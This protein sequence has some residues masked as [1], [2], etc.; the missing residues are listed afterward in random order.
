MIGCHDQRDDR[1]TR[2][3]GDI[4]ER[5]AVTTECLRKLSLLLEVIKSREL[6][7]CTHALYRVLRTSCN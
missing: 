7:F 5:L 6:I 1:Q 3:H 4:N 2:E